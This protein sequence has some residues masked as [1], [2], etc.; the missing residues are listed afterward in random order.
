MGLVNT[1]RLQKSYHQIMESGSL[2][3]LH[4]CVPNAEEVDEKK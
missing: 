3:S 1:K 4:N 2:E